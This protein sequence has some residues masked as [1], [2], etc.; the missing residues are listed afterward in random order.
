MNLLKYYLGL[1]LILS[2]TGIEQVC[3]QDKVNTSIAQSVNRTE[4]IETFLMFK[5]IVETKDSVKLRALFYEGFHDQEFIDNA[6]NNILVNRSLQ[7]QIKNL[8]AKRLQFKPQV[9][10]FIEEIAQLEGLCY[11]DTY[12]KGADSLDG[13]YFAKI[14]GIY[15][16]VYYLSAG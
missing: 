4:A 7:S 12:R 8:K 6:V 9:P 11:I 5:H 2:L 10:K 14:N 1:T 15:R 16:L 3:A 13:F